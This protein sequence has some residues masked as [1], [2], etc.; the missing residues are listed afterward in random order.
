ML[1]FLRAETSNVTIFTL[2]LRGFTAQRNHSDD[3]CDR[4]RANM[5]LPSVSLLARTKSLPT[6]QL[7]HESL[8]SQ[9][10][11][12]YCKK[13]KY[14]KTFLD[15]FQS[16]TLLKCSAIKGNVNIYIQP[17]LAKPKLGKHIAWHTWEVG[18]QE[19]SRYFLQKQGLCATMRPLWP[20][21]KLWNCV[22]L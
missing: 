11:F 17:K 21:F 2:P 4:W 18:K 20:Y 6:Q 8:T 22:Q 5:Q 14:W 1:L 7:H 12:K 19:G 16:T 3:R 15:L 10:S 13:K 9:P